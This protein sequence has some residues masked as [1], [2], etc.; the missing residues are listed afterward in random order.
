MFIPNRVLY[1][2]SLTVNDNSGTKCDSA[3]DSFTAVVNAKPTSI[4]KVR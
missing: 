4:I 1:T 2:V 3:S